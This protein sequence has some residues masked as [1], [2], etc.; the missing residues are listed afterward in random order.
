MEGQKAA[1]DSVISISKGMCIILM[2]IAH[3]DGHLLLTK[4]IYL[5]HVPLFFFVSGYFNKGTESL[6]ELK[7]RLV[8]RIKRLYLPFVFYGLLFLLF[9]NLFL[10][11]G[12]YADGA[13]HVTDLRSFVIL[14]LELLLKMN[15]PS[16]LLG[17]MWFVRSLFIAAVCLDLGLFI[18]RKVRYSKLILL[19][20]CLVVTLVIKLFPPDTP[21]LRQLVIASLGGFFF[22]CGMLCRTIPRRNFSIWFMAFSLVILLMITFLTKSFWSINMVSV[23]DTLAFM[24]IALVGI[25]FSLSLSKLINSTILGQAFDYVGCNTMPILALHVLSF[26]P[27]SFL[28]ILIYSL[29]PDSISQFMTISSLG[30]AWW[31]AYVAAGI[32]IP[33]FLNKLLYMMRVRR[34]GI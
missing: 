5:F 30:G 26:K 10:R 11:W 27:V 15:V 24:A 9:D 8:K 32:V 23:K 19:L 25:Q 21:V 6:S 29:P 17:P 33:L 31:I 34:P 22:M 16:Q 18:L 12:F 28:A 1:H 2:V 4:F 3:T 20:A 13:M 7:S 14:L